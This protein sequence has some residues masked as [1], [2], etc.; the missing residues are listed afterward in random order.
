MDDMLFP[1]G[2]ELAAEYGLVEEVATRYC[3]YM[4]SGHNTEAEA[5]HC[6]LYDWD[7]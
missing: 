5:I 7:L 3:D 4:L 1:E 6:A 2:I